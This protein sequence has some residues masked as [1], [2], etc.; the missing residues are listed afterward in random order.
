MWKKILKNVN[1][2]GRG[3]AK[4]YEDANSYKIIRHL[5][6]LILSKILKNINN[7]PWIGVSTYSHPSSSSSVFI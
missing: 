4:T 2:M 6:H 3:W 7:E 5:P 1:K